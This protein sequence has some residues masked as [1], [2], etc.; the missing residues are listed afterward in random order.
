MPPGPGRLGK[1]TDSFQ[2]TLPVA[3][4]D[5]S[6]EIVVPLSQV[7]S[8]PSPIG[9]DLLSA[10]KNVSRFAPDRREP[11]ASP[12]VPE[13]PEPPRI[14]KMALANTATYI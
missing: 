9:R 3:S 13:S 1:P 11:G 7:D 14:Y 4:G 8:G 10:R 12:T 6:A 2:S 5:F